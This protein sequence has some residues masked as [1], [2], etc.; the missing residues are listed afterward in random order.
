MSSAKSHFLHDIQVIGLHT[1]DCYTSIR[2][3]K[4]KKQSP[5]SSSSRHH[6]HSRAGDWIYRGEGTANLILAYNGSSPDFVG[7]VLRVQKVNRNGTNCEEVSSDLS[8]H[9]GLLWNGDCDLLSAPTREIAEH[10]YVQHVMS[11]LLGSNH[12]DA[13][14]FDIMPQR[15][16][17]LTLKKH[18]AK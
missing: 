1:L 8:I 11:P 2:P 13:R 4:E 9:E 7:K 6:S 3:A 5:G 14:V 12:V 16:D 15:T 17:F 18:L 10:I